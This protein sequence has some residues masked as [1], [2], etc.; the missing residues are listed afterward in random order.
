MYGNLGDRS[1]A[2]LAW[3]LVTFGTLT[4]HWDNFNQ[5]SVI[6]RGTVA[7]HMNHSIPM[8]FRYD[9]FHCLPHDPSRARAL[10]EIPLI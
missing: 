6:D 5:D 10:I 4:Q 2:S 3:E 9:L 1:L 8:Q 7:D